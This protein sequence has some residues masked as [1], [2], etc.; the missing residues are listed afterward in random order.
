MSV[1]QE[2]YWPTHLGESPVIT[3]VTVL[4]EQA[5]LLGQKT[6]N[7]VMGKVESRPDEGKLRHVLYLIVPT[8]SNYRYYLLSIAQDLSI[9][10]LKINDATSS[11]SIYAQDLEDFRVK[12]KE[13]LSSDRV[14][15]IIE[16]LLSYTLPPSTSS[17]SSE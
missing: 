3:P 9:Y 10:P 1:Q 6:K 4:K 11:S 16:T 12:L 13:I 7:L 15:R 17:V 2:D 5:A 8:L 14:K